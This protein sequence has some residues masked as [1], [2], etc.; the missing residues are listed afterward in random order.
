M[1]IIDERVSNDV[2]ISSE[3][4]DSIPDVVIV[5]Q[6]P[7]NSVVV[8][9]FVVV[10]VFRVVESVVVRL[11]DDNEEI[12]VIGFV[13]DGTHGSVTVVVVVSFVED[14][15]HG[16]GS[17]VVVSVFSI[18]PIQTGVRPISVTPTIVTEK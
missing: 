3:A 9:H 14:G 18:S 11:D 10:N 5:V 12:V 2:V 16:S 15:P 17:A 7:E 6:A 1:E 8:V 4:V 13:D